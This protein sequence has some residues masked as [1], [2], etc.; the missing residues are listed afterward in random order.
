MAMTYA[1]D[2]IAAQAA[3]VDY[4]RQ[5]GFG[6]FSTEMSVSYLLLGVPKDVRFTGVVMDVDQLQNNV[7]EKQN[8]YEGWLAFNRASGMRSSPPKPNRP[9]VCPPPKLWL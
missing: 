9:K 7:E 8:C 2:R 6:T 4:Y 3:N 5:P 1:T